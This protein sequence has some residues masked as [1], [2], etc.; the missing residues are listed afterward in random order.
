M[1]TALASFVEHINVSD[2][3]TKNAIIVHALSS[4]IEKFGMISLDCLDQAQKNECK[5]TA[6]TLASLCAKAK[7]GSTPETAFNTL[8]ILP[9]LS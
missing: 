9:K 7:G 6:L 4:K 3:E 2:A 5:T 8:G 1:A